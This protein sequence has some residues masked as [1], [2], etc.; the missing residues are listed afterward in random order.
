MG[1]SARSGAEMTEPDAVINARL[2]L[3]PERL[4]AD[5]LE[6]AAT[7]KLDDSEFAQI[8]EEF[9]ARVGDDLSLHPPPQA[10]P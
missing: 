5:L 2:A 9:L 4:R 1:C 7:T 8:V 6:A 10:D 3:L